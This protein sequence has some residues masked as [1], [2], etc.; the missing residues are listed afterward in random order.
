MKKTTVLLILALLCFNGKAQKTI[1]EWS[2]YDDKKFAKKAQYFDGLGFLKNS[3]K[4]GWVTADQI[5][6][7][8]NIGVLSYVVI[9]PT[10][11]QKSP[12]SIYT[13]YLTSSGTG[14]VSD[15]LFPMV[16][17]GMKTSIEGKGM[18]LL[19]PEQYCDTEEKK[20]LFNTTEFEASKLMK[21]SAA[22][23]SYIRSPQMKDDPTGYYGKFVTMANSDYKVSRAIGKFSKEMGLDA[24]VVYEQTLWFDGKTMSLGPISICLIGP[25]PTPETE[26]TSYA[27]TGPLKGYMEGFIFGNVNLAPPK[28]FE[29]AVVKKKS[30]AWEDLTGFDVIFKRITDGLIDYMNAEFDELKK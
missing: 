30:I 9:Q 22:I 4:Q 14:K 16:L 5:P 7:V 3:I 20:N 23:A 18:S 12:Y 6:P 29:L 24:M 27:P 10:F 13:N 21:S 17:D 26:K 1:K 2:E 19:I 8:K 25:N 28:A 15:K 11:T